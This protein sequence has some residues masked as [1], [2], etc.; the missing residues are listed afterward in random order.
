VLLVCVGTLLL[1]FV[2][3]MICGFSLK[4]CRSATGNTQSS[5]AP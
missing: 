2:I 4:Y 1:Y 5:A 3:G